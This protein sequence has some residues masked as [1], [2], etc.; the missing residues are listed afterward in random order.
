MNFHPQRFFWLC[1]ACALVVPVELFADTPDESDGFEQIRA[2]LA[3]QEAEIR[4]L[5]QRLDEQP[6]RLPPVDGS[7]APQTGDTAE[8]QSDDSIIPATAMLQEEPPYNGAPRRPP[9]SALPEKKKDGFPTVKLTGFTQL[10]DGNYSQTALNRATV[11][12]AQN[13]VGFRRARLAAYGKV[14]EFT[15]YIVEMDFATAG[16]PSFFDVYGEQTNLPWLGSVRIGQYVQPFSVDAMSG[17]RN[18]PFLER[19][20]PF[21]AFVPFRR[22][23]IESYNSTEDQRLNWAYSG[24]KTGGFNNAPLGDDRYAT[25]LGN[26][27]GYSFSTR[28]TYLLYY[29]ELAVDRYLWHIGGAF[30]YS[31]LGEN[32]APGSGASG[33]AGGGPSPFYQSKVLPEFGTLGYS[34]NSQSFG[35]AVSGTPTM[36]DSGKYAASAFELYGVETVAQAGTVSFQSEWMATV[37]NSVV[38]PIFYNGAYAEVM[39]RPTGET[40]PYDKTTGALKNVVPFT[41]FFGLGRSGG[42]GGWGALELAARLSYVNEVNPTSLNG[43]YYNSTTNTFTAGATGRAGNGTLTDTTLGVT[44]FLNAHTKLQ[45]NWIHCMLDNVVKGY[46]IADLWVSRFQIDF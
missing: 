44:W 28:L 32:N 27:G 2:Q 18:L 26:V 38:G 46:S 22:V 33:N 45:F 15:N 37:V 1:L 8:P 35:N 42:F 21:L 10:D 29:D 19:S 20:L 17:F 13:G 40:R 39:Y 36:I 41:D 23:G 31:R 25:D 12:D 24:F 43:H 14:T 34:E 7:S 16:R 9:L 11:G 3:R 6:L 4:M 5:R 30:D